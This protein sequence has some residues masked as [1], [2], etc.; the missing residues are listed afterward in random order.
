MDSPAT[1]DHPGDDAVDAVHE[2]APTTGSI[3]SAIIALF[4]G[5]SYAGRSAGCGSTLLLTV[6]SWFGIS[7]SRLDPQKRQDV[8]ESTVSYSWFAM[9]IA[10]GAARH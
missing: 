4:R 1:Y 7:G 9:M 8:C 6:P 10:S 3:A 5:S 2:I